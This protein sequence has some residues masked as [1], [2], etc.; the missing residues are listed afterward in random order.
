MNTT[1][2]DFLVENIRAKDVGLDGQDR[3]V[4][5][6][7]TDPKEQWRPLVPLLLKAIPELLVYGDYDSDSRTGPAIWLRCLVD[8]VL[9]VPAL[10]EDKTPIIYLPGVSR[11]DLR[12]G[13]ECRE[14][15]RPLV[16]LM[17]RGSLWLQQNGNDWGLLSFLG[18]KNTINLDISREQ[19]TFEALLRALPEVAVT[20]LGQ[21]RGRRLEADDFN[22]M[23]SDDLNRD[24]LCWLDD[25]DN[26]KARLGEDRW[27]A[28]RSRCQDELQIDP[29]S[30]ADVSAGEYLGKAEGAW[31]NVWDRFKEAPTIYGKVA[32]LLVRSRPAGELP[33]IRERWPDLNEED[34][35]TVRKELKSILELS[36]EEACNTISLLEKQHGTRREWVWANMNRS[37]MAMALEPLSRLAVA[38]S[39]VIGGTSPAEIA[40]SY[41]QRGWQ[42]DAAAWEVLSTCPSNDEALVKKV[43]RHLLLP[44]LEDS[45]CVFQKLIQKNPLPNKSEQQKVEVTTNQC[46]VFADGLR[47]DL[48]QKLLE[49]LEGRG[50]RGQLNFRWAATPTVTATAKPAV[51]PVADQISGKILGE[52]F[53]PDF[54]ESGKNTNAQNIR[55]SLL[56]ENY[57][58]LGGD[59]FDSPMSEDAKGWL[60]TGEIDKL[61]HKLEARLARQIPEEL[62]RLTERIAGLFDAGW[63]SVR[64]VTDHGWLFLPGG[65]PK[66]DL[67][68]HLTDSRWARCAVVSGQSDPEI[69]QH[70]WYWNQS[71]F[72]ATPP[73]VSCFNKSPEYAHGG[74]S[75]Q[76]CLIPDLLIEHSGDRQVRVTIKAIEWHSLRCQIEVSCSGAGG[77]YIS[78]DLRNAHPAGISVVANIKPLTEDSKVS[79]VLAGDEYLEAELV[80]VLL[81]QDGNILVQK[82][83]KIG[84]NS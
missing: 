34:D 79:L 72:F 48:G 38:A 9:K 31:K 67:P 43:V 75:L 40:T 42:G 78:A 4:A 24:V 73:G 60:E 33:F 55:D 80:L 25:P 58:I 59:E 50:F 20:P 1:A 29:D 76:E 5:I 64:V 21:I 49:R 82:P 37:P 65:L 61:G 53:Y 66:V 52:L 6:L 54:K 18:S 35:E 44:W 41:L 69:Q 39:S 26:T 51:T 19:A 71:Q 2:L 8:R 81:D 7:W 15:L 46:L 14:T 32:D 27:G 83:T 74:L 84:Q 10:P 3:P 36:H 57:Q 70:P 28:F 23:L 11:Q 17:Y 12:A 47:F 62:D 77:S 56:S 16:E 30:V 68:K 13:E 22:R 63:Q 45:A